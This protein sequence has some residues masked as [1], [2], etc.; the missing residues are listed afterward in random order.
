MVAPT[1]RHATYQ[2]VL[3]APELMIAEI[4][5]GDLY[6]SPRL[7]NRGVY[8]AST[9]LHAIGASFDRPRSWILLHKPEVHYRDE[10]VVPDIAGWRRDRM[11]VIPD[12]AYLELAPD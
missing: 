1:K 6:L 3:D 8:V 11:P 12:V 2:D 9:V 4:L 10:V 5:N 7:N